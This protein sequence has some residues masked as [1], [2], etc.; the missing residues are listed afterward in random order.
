MLKP[1]LETLGAALLPLT[2]VHIVIDSLRAVYPVH[3]SWYLS[4]F[5]QSPV[6]SPYWIVVKKA[7]VGLKQLNSVGPTLK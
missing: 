6:Q 2:F 4:F 7:R 3:E 5:L 1:P